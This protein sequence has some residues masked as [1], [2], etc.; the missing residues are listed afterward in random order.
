MSID[1]L[2]GHSGFVGGTLSLQHAFAARFNTSNI[3]AIVDQ[4]FDTVVCAAAPGSMFTANRD[5][6]RDRA[7]I[8]ALIERLDKVRTRRFVLISSI[9]VLADFAAGN[10][11]STQAFQEELPYGRNRRA[12]EAYCETRFS[13][14]LIVRLP[15]LFG[16]G[17]RKNFI[18]DLMNPLPSMLAPARLESLTG[19]LPASLRDAMARLYAPDPNGMCSI[20]RD[21]LNKDSCRRDLEEAVRAVKMSAT[22]FHNPD[23]TYQYYDLANLWRDM[24]IAAK[25]E[26][27]HVHLATEPLRAGDIHARLLGSDMPSSDARLHREDMHTRHASLWGRE[28][29]YLEDAAT[30]LDRLNS[31]F[32]S[33]RRTA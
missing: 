9:A 21:A 7:Q 4:Q 3:D 2:I 6:E 24:E 27:R 13:D 19:L 33:Q 5:P 11:E 30:V 29:P 14:C 18:F 23:T 1:G 8:D 10:D 26:L 15:A 32:I 22:Q 17:L 25:F 20:D 16:P 28:G 12:L 31:F